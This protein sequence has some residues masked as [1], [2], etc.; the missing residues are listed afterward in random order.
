M[1]ARSAQFGL[2]PFALLLCGVS[3]ASAQEAGKEAQPAAVSSSV[4]APEVPTPG[5][6]KQRIA[7]I[8]PNYNTVDASV[9]FQRI[10]PARKFYIAR[11]DAFDSPVFFL[12]SI[13]AA[14]SQLE[15]STPEFGQGLAGYG[16]RYGASLADRSMGN[17][18]TEGVF[19]SLF[20]QDPRY[21]RKG[22][23]GVAKRI[24]YA[25]S[26]VAVAKNDH[27]KWTFNASEFAGNS[28]AVAI[29]NLY[30]YGDDSRTASSNVQ[31]LGIQIGADAGSN[32][33]REFWP[34][35]RR[36]LF[37]KK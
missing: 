1:R 37:H 20:R 9:P 16:K 8:L 32:L 15:N 2:A 13:Y 14:L 26:R 34:D 35:I 30:Y 6:G 12:P 10:S 22:S 23:G 31:R 29:S 19:P 24:A 5:P 28:T 25:V 7:G 3:Y 11:R 36:N 4:P 18:F 33:L 27:G 17:F 21:F